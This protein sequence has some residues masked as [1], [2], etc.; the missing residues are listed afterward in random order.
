MFLPSIRDDDEIG[1]RELRRK[2]EAFLINNTNVGNTASTMKTV[3]EFMRSCNLAVKLRRRLSK[4]PDQC[5]RCQNASELKLSVLSR[6]SKSI[7]EQDSSSS[8]D[9]EGDEEKDTGS[10]VAE[11]VDW[12]VFRKSPQSTRDSRL[13]TFNKTRD[14]PKCMSRNLL[15]DTLGKGIV[16]YNPFQFVNVGYQGLNGFS[17]FRSYPSGFAAILT[18]LCGAVEIVTLHREDAANIAG[19]V[20]LDLESLPSAIV[21]SSYEEDEERR[22]R[23][24][25]EYRAIT[26]TLCM[27][28]R[29]RKKVFHVG[30]TLVMPSGTFFAF[31]YMPSSSLSARNN[32]KEN[33]DSSSSFSSMAVASSSFAQ[34]NLPVVFTVKLHLDTISIPKLF[35]A[36]VESRSVGIP[37]RA[38]VWNAAHGAMSRVSIKRE[39]STQEDLDILRCIVH[40]SRAYSNVHTG[41]KTFWDWQSLI[42][43]L[44]ALRNFAIESRRIDASGSS[45]G[46]RVPRLRTSRRDVVDIS[47]DIPDLP[48]EAT[49]IRPPHRLQ[50]QNTR[51]NTT[52]SNSKRKRD[53]HMYVCCELS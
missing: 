19:Y 43:D 29:A 42:F 45:G 36:H 52:S 23:M 26:P 22:E 16:E 20:D 10:C 8:S 37:H 50:H 48:E 25:K 17:N 32:E 3:V 46:G 33:I 35:E 47:I 34:K 15:L 14:Y 7:Q 28:R 53:D 40:I 2:G 5:R 49:C 39:R 4:C 51:L 41:D 38:M 27:I 30:E 12:Q 13:K 18:V 24:R 9:E 1:A 31:R 44:E 21:T 11:I 6:F